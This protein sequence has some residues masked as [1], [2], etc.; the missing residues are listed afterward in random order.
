MT[1]SRYF[2]LTSILSIIGLGSLVYAGTFFHSFHFDDYIYIVQNFAIKSFQHLPDI[3][4]IYP[5]RFITFL[6][7]AVNFHFHQ[8]NV[9]GYHLVNLCVHLLNAVLVWWLTRLTLSTPLMKGNRIS[10]HVDI[11]SLFA[12]LIFVA[13]PL[14]TQGVTYIWQRAAALSTMFY[15]AS[16]CLYVRSR[17]KEKKT[18]ARC[19]YW[20]AVVIAAMAMFTKEIA[21]TLPLMVLLY[22]FSFFGPL[23]RADWKR[24]APFL[25]TLLLIPLTMLFTRAREQEIHSILQSVTPLQYLLT[26]FKVIVTYLRLVFLPINQSIDYDIAISKSFFE[27]PV[28][29]SFLFLA[30]SLLLAWRLFAKYRI[31]AFG[32]F[33]FFLTLLP[34]SSFLPLQDVIYEHRLYLPL[35]GFSIFLACGAYYVL[36]RKNLRTMFIVLTIL[37]VAEAVLAYERNKVWK[38]EITL[39]SDAVQKAPRKA[40]PYI[41][42][43]H[44]Y[45]EQGDLDRALADFDK[46]IGLEPDLP[47]PYSDRCVVYQTKGDLGQAL[48]DC[49]RAIE[50]DPKAARTYSNRGMVYQM[51]GDFGRALADFNTAIATDP[52]SAEAYSNRG[53]LYQG[54]GDLEGALADYRKAAEVDPVLANAYSNQGLIYQMKGELRLGLAA[55]NKAIAIDPHSANSYLNRGM[56]Y[57]AEDDLDQALSDF[58][59]AIRID[60]DMPLAY[61]NRGM[62]Y[63][64][65]GELDQALVDYN[66]AIALDPKSAFAYSNRGSVYQTKGDF[67][68]AIFNY[69]KAIEVDPD[70]AEAYSNRGKA[71]EAKGEIKKAFA[72][73]TKALEIKPDLASARESLSGLEK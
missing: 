29:G 2:K 32:A 40:R 43:G 52:N 48:S 5:C 46:A 34:E 67:N 16:L 72:D 50:I 12:A 4:K 26:Q 42:R 24:V 7:L 31:L 10:R 61:N 28:M 22:E 11:L 62:I 54:Q 33:W 15:L 53:I 58:S 63:Q 21:I 56:V 3:W 37:V 51:K 66:K 23:K 70:L 69:N 49:N 68:Q 71:H 44:A 55:C 27:W 19:F 9:F 39:W 35:V 20:S 6:S 41:N 64:I 38:D 59:Q 73:Y 8:L 57:R 18:S 45:L 13:H 30:G 65:K 14:Q 60:P 36:A 47:E 1:S 25:A 17:L